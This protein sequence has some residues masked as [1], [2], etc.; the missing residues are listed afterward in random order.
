MSMPSGA[1]TPPRKRPRVALAMGCP[2]GIAPELTARVLAD[3]GIAAAMD[4][5]VIGDRRVLDKGAAVAGVTLDLDMIR[6]D[7]PVPASLARPVLVDLRHLDPAS[8][9]VG[10]V[11]LGAGKFAV[12]NFWRAIRL[13]ASGGADAVA[14]SPF[15]KAAMRVAHPSYED[16]ISFLAEELDFKDVA[17]E[18]N[19]LPDLWNARVTS[20]VPISKVA[21]LITHD[22]V[23][24]SLVLTDQAMRESGY[25]RP[26]IAI[27]ALNPHAGDGGNF[28]REDMDVLEPVVAEGKQRGIACEGP[29][30]SDTVFLRAKKGEFDAVLTMYHDQGQIAMKLIG[31]DQGV[32]MLGG[33]P[34]PLL[35][36]AHGS[37]Y[38]IAGKGIANPGAMFNAM[39]LAGRMAA[40][41]LR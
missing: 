18:F 28:G 14:F 17:S 13:A 10:E 3:A 12:E 19:I 8:I 22:N 11:S 30:P 1:S 16:E 25:A 41:R 39:R 4:I 2:A 27:A 7:D 24:R 23:L 6:P 15:N 31:F 40:A 34:F 36:A 29:F 38:D 21:S 20:H 5:V 32:T 33:Y 26:R 35:T 9:P 37:A